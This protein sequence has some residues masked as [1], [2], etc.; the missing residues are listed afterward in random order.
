M[1]ENQA[2]R[3]EGGRER[4]REE[5]EGGMASRIGTT[6][7]DRRDEM[8][9]TISKDNDGNIIYF[10]ICIYSGQGAACECAL[11]KDEAAREVMPGGGGRAVRSDA[12][13]VSE[14]PNP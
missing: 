6:F 14:K 3:C 12:T 9:L 2:F 1:G 7:V 8:I 5:R 13:P 11:G 10:F 4:G